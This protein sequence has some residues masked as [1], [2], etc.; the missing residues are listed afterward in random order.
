MSDTA[1][2]NDAVIRHNSRMFAGSFLL[3]FLCAPVIYIGVVQA[4]L[5][6]K[7]GTSAT[8][9]NLPMS[10]FQFA[11]IAPLFVVWFVPHCR[12]KYAAVVSASITAVL[13]ALVAVVLFVPCSAEVRVWTV[14]AHGLSQ[15]L[16]S[17]VSLVFLIQCLKRGATP[18]G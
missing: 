12:E 17:S 14:I 6:D 13:T 2:P 9:A 3:T 4:A 10:T 7:L 18:E 15:G 5:L 1:A 8:I 11:Q 16:T